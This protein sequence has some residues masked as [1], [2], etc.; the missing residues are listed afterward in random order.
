VVDEPKQPSGRGPK[1]GKKHT[2][3]RGHNRKSIGGK[4]K[5]FA[6]KAQKKRT[7]AEEDARKA[8]ELWTPCPT[9]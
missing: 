1:G 5:R 8:W 6:K 4:R 2:P 7:Q 3:G 9:T